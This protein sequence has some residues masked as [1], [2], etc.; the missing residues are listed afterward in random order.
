MWYPHQAHQFAV[1]LSRWKGAE[2]LFQML[3]RS[4]YGQRQEPKRGNIIPFVLN[5]AAFYPGPY[6]LFLNFEYDVGE[7]HLSRYAYS[8][9]Q[10]IF[11][12][13]K[14]SLLLIE[15]AVLHKCLLIPL[16]Y[17]SIKI[18]HLY[19]TKYITE[20]SSDQFLRIYFLH[21]VIK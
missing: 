2:T 17:V 7:P 13:A 9:I 19:H 6:E 4:I 15:K 11:I 14:V 16:I 12:N 8:F 1:Y 18:Y 20:M 5:T 21:M 10:L 3:H